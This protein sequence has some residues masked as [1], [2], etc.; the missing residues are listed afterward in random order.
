MRLGAFVIPGELNVD[1]VVEKYSDIF[2]SDHN[3]PYES[4]DCHCVIDSPY[5]RKEDALSTAP[6][7]SFIT[8]T[9]SV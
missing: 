2:R 9:V 4:C 5:E 1:H 7:Y 6:T 3:A 8:R